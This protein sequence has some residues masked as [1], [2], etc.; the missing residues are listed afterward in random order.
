MPARVALP[1]Q[2]NPTSHAVSLQT[3]LLSVGIAANTSHPDSPLP[4]SP[5]AAD[6]PT[7]MPAHLEFA[8][9]KTQGLV[10]HGDTPLSKSILRIPE[11]QVE[12]VGQPYGAVNAL[13]RNTMTWIWAH[14]PSVPQGPLLVGP[15]AGAVHLDTA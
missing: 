5:A 15:A 1:D 7:R 6:Q 11:A 3:H 4:R 14:G 8:A 2:A 9:P 13:R 10:A 12:T